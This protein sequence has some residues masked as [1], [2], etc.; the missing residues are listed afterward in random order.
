MTLSIGA[1]DNLL[2]IINNAII[3]KTVPIGQ[4]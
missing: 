2:I 1:M 4:T 3:Y